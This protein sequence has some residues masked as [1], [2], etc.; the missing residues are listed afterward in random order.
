MSSPTMQKKL[1]SI[2]AG[3]LML[4]LGAAG[5][6]EGNCVTAAFDKFPSTAQET[7]THLPSKSVRVNVSL[8]ISGK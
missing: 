6:E 1:L 3:L 2:A 5:V 8:C 4:A 7:V